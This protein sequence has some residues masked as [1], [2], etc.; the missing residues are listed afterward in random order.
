MS[1]GD[2]PRLASA[3]KTRRLELGLPRL[4]AANEAGISKDTWKRVEEA[5][6]VRELNYAKID[7]VLGWATGSCIVILG[8]GHPI[9]VG[10]SATAPDVTIA[11]TTDA[12]RDARA[13]T[14]VSSLLGTTDLPD[15]EIKPLSDRIID[16][17][18]RQGLL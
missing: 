4:K 15:A 11:D 14:V 10:P 8:G 2:L 9:P 6:P 13:K 7:V 12:S 3:V 18:K 17:L 5:A 16:D 1:T